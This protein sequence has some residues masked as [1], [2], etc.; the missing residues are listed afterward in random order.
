MALKA[1]SRPA[2]I[3]NSFSQTE[4]RLTDENQSASV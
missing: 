1:R 2:L 4:W 3:S